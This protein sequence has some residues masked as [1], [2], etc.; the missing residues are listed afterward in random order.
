MS[1]HAGPSTRPSLLIRLRDCQDHEAWCSF[2]RLYGPLIFRFCR[3]RGLREQDAAEVM[4]EAL[5]QIA[6]SIQTFDYQ[7]QRGRFRGWVGSIVRSKIVEFRR[8]QHRQ[9]KVVDVTVEQITTADSTWDDVWLEHIVQAALARVQQRLA[10]ATWTAFRMVWLDHVDVDLVAAELERD[11]AWVYLAKSRGLKLL[12]E[13]V[14]L[15]ADE[16]FDTQQ[17]LP[18]HHHALPNHA[19]A[20]D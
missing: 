18:R 8:K 9:P 12:R 3:G 4:Q 10:I 16:P 19:A 7:P 14:S 11:V 20:T 2:S 1:T 13:E 6:R 15:L 17:N 5:L